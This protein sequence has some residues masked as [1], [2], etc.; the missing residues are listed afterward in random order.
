[1]AA[2]L[3]AIWTTTMI[4]TTH[5]SRAATKA[6]TIAVRI[7]HMLAGQGPEVQGAVIG[8]LV[9]VF[10]AG[11]HPGLRANQRKL[12]DELIDDLIPICIEEMIDAGKVPPEMADEWR[13][14]MQ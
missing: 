7:H 11:H 4:K 1:M 9:A 12:L 6:N 14:K 8:E 10:L 2:S 5:T 3:T 13:G